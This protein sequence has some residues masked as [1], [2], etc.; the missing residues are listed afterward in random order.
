MRTVACALVM[1]VCSMAVADEN[2]NQ[3]RGPRGDGTSTAKGLPVKFAEGSPEIVWKTPVPGR[4]WSSPVIWGEQV[5]LTSATENGHEL[6]AVCV[7]RETGR[8]V[9][10]LKLFDVE[11]PQQKHDFNSYASPTPAIEAGRLYVTFGSPGTACLD[12]ETGMVLWSRRDL[13]C[14]HY[15]GAGSSPILYGDTMFLN[16]DGIDRQ[17]VVAFDKKTG[18]T[19]W[20][21]NRSIDFLD[22]QPD[23]QPL[24]GGDYRKAYGTCQIASLDGRTTVLSQGSKA[25]YAY[26]PATG[27]ELWRVEERGGFSGCARPVVGHGLVFLNTGQGRGQLLAIRPGKPGE[28]L[29]ADAAQSPPTQLQVIWRGKRNVPKKPSLLLVNDLLFGI[30]DNGVATCW[31]AKTGET[32]WNERIGGNYSASPLAAAGRI[33]FFSEE[34]KTT[35]VVAEREFKKLAE[36]QLE[37]GFMASPAVSGRAL[38]LR[39]RTHLYR[40]E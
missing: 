2:W 11:H 19:L 17:Y 39:T 14:D 22:L 3:F 5:W 10:D 36:N 33:Y 12:T 25:L 30:D 40:I 27:A 32:L 24:A 18:R 29:D 1:C 4:A 21:T 13:P 6:F 35:V 8:I 15:R 31:E 37:G 34:G 28:T 38:F 7:E 23:G 16:F 20:Q 26:D 9:R